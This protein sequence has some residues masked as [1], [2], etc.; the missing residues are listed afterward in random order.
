[1]ITLFLARGLGPRFHT[2][3]V[4]AVVAEASV[5]PV[6]AAV[7]SPGHLNVYLKEEINF[8]YLKSS[9]GLNYAPERLLCFV[10]LLLTI[11]D[12][13]LAM[14]NLCLSVSS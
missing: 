9:R 12:P 2:P 8:D 11:S 10:Q 4:I 6:V 13:L 7:L 5:V 14:L 3:A 1:M